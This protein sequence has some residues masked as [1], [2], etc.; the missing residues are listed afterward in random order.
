MSSHIK[1]D[2]FEYKVGDDGIAILTIDQVNNPT[3]L[4]SFEFIQAYIETAKK[5]IADDSVKGVILTS[6]R[7]MF[8]PGADLR[9]LRKPIESSEKQL[10]GMLAMH[11]N[12]REIEHGG[13]PF[14]A[15]INGTAMGGGMELCL[16]CH[17]R[18]ALNSPK[19]KF[20][21]SN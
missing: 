10:E 3:N 1:N 11:R 12:Y 15:A 4:F 9:E 16:T 14:V 19:I 5:A 13:K 20:E 8:M 7:R 6:G 2:L 17:H 21:N 18:I